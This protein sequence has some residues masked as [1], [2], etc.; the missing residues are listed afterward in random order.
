MSLPW[1]ARA[2]FTV[3]ML[4]NG[5]YKSQRIHGVNAGCMPS[6]GLS[7]VHMARDLLMVK[8]N[9]NEL[10]TEA[11]VKKKCFIVT[12]IGADNSPTRRAADGLI[13]AVMRPVLKNLGFEVYVAHE[14]AAP[15]SIT[16]Q[17]IEHVVYDELVVANLSEL[18]PNVMYELAVRHCV[19]LPII[20]LAENGTRLP[21][22]I[23]DERTLFFENDMAGVVDLGPRLAAAVE[24]AMSLEEADNPVLRVTSSKAL[25]ESVETDDAQSFLIKKLDYIES[26]IGEVK[27]G[28]M[29]TNFA[30]VANAPGNT[31]LYQ[32][33]MEGEATK[34]EK[35]RVEVASMPGVIQM[36]N[37]KTSTDD[38]KI[39]FRVRSTIELNFSLLGDIC[40][41]LGVSV[42]VGTLRTG[43]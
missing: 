10:V 19:G 11:E 42:V 4:G 27:S 33:D 17:V 15:G 40:N 36:L 7:A 6:F 23:S 24:A 16:K 35:A 9:N 30:K 13:N 3:R 37:V 8:K 5:R 14:I 18:N 20:V 26:F 22:D 2:A 32:L 34:C 1:H 31:W 21:F 25:R 39:R 43:L 38:A 29:S 28:A 41:K 12:P